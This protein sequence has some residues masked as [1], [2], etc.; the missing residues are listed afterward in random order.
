MSVFSQWSSNII[1]FA[2]DIGLSGLKSNICSSDD[3]VFKSCPAFDVK[4]WGE[5]KV[6]PL[7]PFIE[8]C[9]SVIFLQGLI[10]HKP[11][12]VSSISFSHSLSLKQTHTHILIHTLSLTFSLSLYLS[13]T[14]RHSHTH[15]HIDTLLHLYVHSSIH[16]CTLNVALNT[17]QLCII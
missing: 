10:T 14:H 3:P 11:S 17:R 7:Q 6:V 5:V 16:P 13:L 4:G 12:Y 8:Q 15:T 1:Y 9:K 2:G